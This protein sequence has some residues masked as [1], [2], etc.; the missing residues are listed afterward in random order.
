MRWDPA[1]KTW[2]NLDVP[3]FKWIDPATKVQV[4]PDESAKAPFLMLPEGKSRLFVPKGL[5]KDGPFP[6]HYEALECP[7]INPMSPQQSNPVVKIW[8]SDLV[9][10]GRGLRPQVSHHRHHLPGHRALAG[11][12][13]DPEPHLA[14]GDDAGDVRGDEPQLWP[15]PRASRRATG[16]R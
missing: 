8:K 16:S 1:A 7:F 3:D 2:K 5:C 12:G 11:R 6:E 9:Q 15:R 10:G 14:G 4:A 13:H